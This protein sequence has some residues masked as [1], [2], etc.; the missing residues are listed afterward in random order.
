MIQSTQLHTYLMQ[1]ISR[2]TH[3]TSG[4]PPSKLKQHKE[5]SLN[6]V[7]AFLYIGHPKF[8]KSPPSISPAEPDHTL[9]RE[10]EDA[11]PFHGHISR[12]LPR[13]HT[14][15][16]TIHARFPALPSSRGIK[17]LIQG[18]AQDAT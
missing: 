10:R 12:H 11:H 5:R 8:S 2:I 14:V 9:M 6:R 3:S 15:C 17:S 18:I 13:I 1:R 16:S 7:A 4:Q